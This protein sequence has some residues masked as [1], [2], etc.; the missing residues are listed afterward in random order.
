MSKKEKDV[1]DM[2][3]RNSKSGNPVLP[4]NF[5]PR[6]SLP[7]SFENLDNLTSKRLTRDKSIDTIFV[8]IS[9]INHNTELIHFVST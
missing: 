8:R 7:I 2:L 4:S 9:L 3:S 5:N 6:I 1:P